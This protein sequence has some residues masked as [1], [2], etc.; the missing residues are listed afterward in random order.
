MGFLN[1]VG[2][3]FENGWKEF[4][5]GLNEIGKAAANAAGVTFNTVKSAV[6]TI[7]D[8]GVKLVTGVGNFVGN[9]VKG[10]QETVN[11]LVAKAGDTVSSVGSSLSLPLAIV[12]GIVGFVFL[13]KK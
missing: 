10:G 3:W 8:D 11:R 12:A 7:H 1:S 9:T 5:T 13:T 4:K 6:S 2:G